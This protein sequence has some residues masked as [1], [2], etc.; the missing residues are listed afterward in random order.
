MLQDA[1]RWSQTL[2]LLNSLD[3]LKAPLLITASS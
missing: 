3:L 2:K 1:F